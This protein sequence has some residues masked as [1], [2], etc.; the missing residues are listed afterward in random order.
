MNRRDFI[1]GSAAFVAFTAIF[2]SGADR[3]EVQAK[4]DFTII[5][6]KRNCIQMRTVITWKDKQYDFASLIDGDDVSLLPSGKVKMN[7][8]IRKQ[9]EYC[10]KHAIRRL[11]KVPVEDI[12]LS[13]TVD[14]A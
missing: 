8:D 12:T 13:Y 4:T 7:K 3:V 10:C 1:K 11:T 14:F 9:Y 5:P 6:E 2:G